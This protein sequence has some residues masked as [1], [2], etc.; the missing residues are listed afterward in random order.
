[1]DDPR[2]ESG[3]DDA[4]GKQTAENGQAMSD[5]L[6]LAASTTLVEVTPGGTLDRIDFTVTK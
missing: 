6:E 2:D 5:A 3:N 1:M 4:G